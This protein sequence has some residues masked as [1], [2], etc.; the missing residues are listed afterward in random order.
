[1]LV[2]TSAHQQ[3]E[4]REEVRTWVLDI[5]VDR[6]V[7][8]ELKKDERGSYVGSL[9][10]SQTGKQFDACIVTGFPILQN[11]VKYGDRSA[12]KEDWNKFL[13]TSKTANDPNLQD[14][15]RFMAQWCN[16]PENASYSF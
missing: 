9:L 7:E 6:K 14:V 15:M 1:M 11:P 12:N 10:C 3:D 13:M 16:A 4:K 8:Q 2:C 5:S